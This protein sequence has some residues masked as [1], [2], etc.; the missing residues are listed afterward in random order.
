M[1]SQTLQAASGN[2]RYYSPGSDTPSVKTESG[3]FFA[4]RLLHCAK[5]TA[6]ETAGQAGCKTAFHKNVSAKEAM[7]EQKASAGTKQL[8][9]DHKTPEGTENLAGAGQ[10]SSTEEMTSASDAEPED[11]HA[12]MDYQ[13][14]FEDKIQEMYVQL[15]NGE[16]EQSFQIGSLSMTLKEW[17]KFLEKF[18][19]IEDAIRE[20]MRQEYEKRAEAEL[21]KQQTDASDKSSLLVTE[22]TSCVYPSSNAGK[23]DD[24][25]ITWY[26]AEGIF[27]RKMGQKEDYEWSVLFTKEGQYDQ[28][29]EFISQFPS[30]WNMRF[31]AHENFWTD[32]LNDNIDIESFMEFLESTDQGVPDYVTTEEDGSMHFDRDKIQWAKYFNTFGNRMYT[33]EEFQKQWEMEIQANAKLK[34]RVGGRTY[35]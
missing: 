31:A 16:N 11:K 19:A 25:Y 24:R 27:C 17:D 22:S 33:R 13:K 21:K 29:M 30:D 26:T 2:A 9:A 4:E 10:T 8:P 20:L 1:V 5:E 23:D 35:V 18:D 34:K 7:E 3:V 12:V 14:F 15:Q 32:F 28:V 6:K